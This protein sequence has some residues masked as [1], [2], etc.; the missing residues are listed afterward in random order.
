MIFYTFASTPTPVKYHGKQGLDGSNSCGIDRQGKS[1]PR[2]ESGNS[3][4]SELVGGEVLLAT[5]AGCDLVD[6]DLKDVCVVV[7]LGDDSH[8]KVLGGMCIFTTDF[9]LVDDSL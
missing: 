3:M 6:V 1:V 9:Q 2:G 7:R 5:R 8:C 4:E